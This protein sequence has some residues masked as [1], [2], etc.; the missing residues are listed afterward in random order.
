MTSSDQPSSSQAPDEGVEGQ[1]SPQGEAGEEMQDDGSQEHEADQGYGT[2]RRHELGVKE[3]RCIVSGE[4]RPTSQMIRFV[5]GPEDEIYPDLAEKLP[6]RGI[7][8]SGQR[9]M[10]EQAV[11]RGLF[12][13]S[14]KA[15]VHVKGDLVELVEHLMQERLFQTLGLARRAG[16][17][18]TGLERV[19]EALD[20]GIL[21]AIIEAQDAGKDGARKLRAKI[22]ASEEDISVLKGLG[23][24]QMGLALGRAN[25]VHAGV[26][27]GSM[28]GKVLA[29]LARLQA[30]GASERTPDEG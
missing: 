19:F 20:K 27:Y 4:T 15:R 13:K 29:D 21:D 1:A 17:L 7:W 26:V 3:R 23:A 8:V 2:N 10:V 18:I 11:K 30:W 9:H 14:A 6:G 5:V 25:V 16:E 28:S 22:K 24:E 12:A